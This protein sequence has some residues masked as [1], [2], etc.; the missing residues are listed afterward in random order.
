MDNFR[1]SKKEP[2]KFRVEKGERYSFCTCGKSE[3]MP[4]CDGAHKEQA[5]GYRSLKFEAAE[6]QDIWLVECLDQND[7]QF[8]KRPP[9]ET[10]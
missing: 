8:I 5:P 4:L 3:K 1:I 7:P 6:T 9:M 2:A 10:K